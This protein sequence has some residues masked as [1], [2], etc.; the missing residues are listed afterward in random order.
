MDHSLDVARDAKNKLE[1]AE[2]AHSDA[3][4]KLRETL[5]QLAEVERPT[6]MQSLP[7]RATKNR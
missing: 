4:K 6:R 7:L 2:R 5:A 3:D 1:V